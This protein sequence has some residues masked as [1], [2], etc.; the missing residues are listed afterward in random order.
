MIDVTHDR[1]DGRFKTQL[2]RKGKLARSERGDYAGKNA[3]TWMVN[4]VGPKGQLTLQFDKKG[5]APVQVDLLIEEEKIYMNGERYFVM[6][7][8]ECK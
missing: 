7:N 3:G 5:L 6:N 4:G 8:K 1:D 2:N